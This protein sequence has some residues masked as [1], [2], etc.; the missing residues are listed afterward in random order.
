[1]T[2]AVVAKLALELTPSEKA[3]IA[4]HDTNV[5][6]AYDSFLHGWEHYQRTTPQDFVKAIPFFERG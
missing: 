3:A 1:V 4:Q 5:P 2:K 6:E